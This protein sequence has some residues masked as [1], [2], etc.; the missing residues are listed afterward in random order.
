MNE[1]DG[2]LRIGTWNLAGRWSD[3]H[4]TLIADQRCDVW[5]LTEVRNDVDLNGYHRHF[6][7]AVIVGRCSWAAVFTRSAL[8]GLMG[9]HGASAAAEVDGVS[10]CSLILPWQSC[11]SRHP[12]VGSRH[13]DKS[14]AAVTDIVGRFREAGSSGAAIGTTPCQAGSSRV[15]QAA[16]FTFRLR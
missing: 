2:R 4:A 15:L 1:A 8:R 3:E 9:P 10:Y 14:G 6:S 11:R 13:G 5:L 12:R 16:E 7:E